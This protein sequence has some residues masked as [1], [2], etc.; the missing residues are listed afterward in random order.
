MEERVIFLVESA[1]AHVRK[2]I[3][4]RAASPQFQHMERA[5]V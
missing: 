3:S 1:V 5:E 2:D 4:T